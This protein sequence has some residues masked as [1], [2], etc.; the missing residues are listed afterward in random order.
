MNNHYVEITRQAFYCLLDIETPCI[1]VEYHGE[2]RHQFYTDKGCN[3][4][5]VYQPFSEP[6]YYIQ[7]INA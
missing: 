2:S 1:D 7:D 4:K 3:L 5:S 6:Q